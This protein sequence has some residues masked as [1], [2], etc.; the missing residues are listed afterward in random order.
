MRPAK[1]QIRRVEVGRWRAQWRKDDVHAE[2]EEKEGD[3]VE[4]RARPGLGIGDC[5]LGRW[6]LEGFGANGAS[7]SGEFWEA[8]GICEQFGAGFTTAVLSTCCLPCFWFMHMQLEYS[9]SAAEN[10]IKRLTGM[11]S[12]D[13]YRSI[14]LGSRIL[15]VTIEAFQ[16]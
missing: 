10:V 14:S 4:K 5:G 6:T 7:S 12:M 11:I 2:G 3:G 8:Q 15:L 13:Q 16:V 1:V 9:R